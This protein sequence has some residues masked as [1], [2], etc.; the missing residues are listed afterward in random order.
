MRTTFS[1]QV[2]RN[3]SPRCC[4]RFRAWR[5]TRTCARKMGRRDICSTQSK[6][7]L[8]WTERV[9]LSEGAWFAH[10]HHGSFTWFQRFSSSGKN[11]LER[12]LVDV[13]NVLG[14]EAA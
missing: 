4:V 3:G 13:H 5:S 1:L 6:E 11:E 7:L 9:G 14:D 2:V 10:F 12:L 8:D